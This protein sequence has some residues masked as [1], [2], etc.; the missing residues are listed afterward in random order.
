[1]EDAAEIESLMC[2]I[3]E[4]EDIHSDSKRRAYVKKRLDRLQ[5]RLDGLLWVHEGKV[6]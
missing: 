2:E 3:D 6:S 5:N 4:I 1:M